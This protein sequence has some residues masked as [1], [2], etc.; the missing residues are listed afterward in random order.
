MGSLVCN[1]ARDLLDHG[2]SLP[3]R[4]RSERLHDDHNRHKWA[5]H[6]WLPKNVII[7]FSRSPLHLIGEPSAESSC[8]RTSLQRCASGDPSINI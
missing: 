1:L 4:Q 6:M 2:R 8:A 7:T 3:P 5:T